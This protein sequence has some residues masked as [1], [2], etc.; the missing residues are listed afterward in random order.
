M[1]PGYH[2]SRAHASQATQQYLGA[3]AD[4]VMSKDES[5]DS[6]LRR[7]AEVQEVAPTT[8]CAQARQ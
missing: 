4:A 6:F 5:R 8:L 2:P 1:S 3:G 7:L